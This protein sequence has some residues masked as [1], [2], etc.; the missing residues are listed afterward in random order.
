VELVIPIV[1]VVAHSH[2]QCVIDHPVG[3]L[4]LSVRLRS[5]S[6]VCEDLVDA[7]QDLQRSFM[8]LILKI[9][10]VVSEQLFGVRMARRRL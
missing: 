5:V 2:R 1:A 10:A 4:T 6:G 9:G 8:S 7:K 3:A